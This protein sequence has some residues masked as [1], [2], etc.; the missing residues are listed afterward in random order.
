[1]KKSDRPGVYQTPGGANKARIPSEAF[2]GH[3]RDTS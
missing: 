2:H 3:K 1:M